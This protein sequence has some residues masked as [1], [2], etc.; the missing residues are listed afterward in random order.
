[1]SQSE[2]VDDKHESPRPLAVARSDDG[3]DTG[4]DPPQGN[5]IVWCGR[6]LGLSASWVMPWASASSGKN[7]CMAFT[8]C[9]LNRSRPISTDDDHVGF[10]GDQIGAMSDRCLFGDGDFR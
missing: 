7:S 9:V 10:L 3:R 6:V 4:V 8:I 2:A 1:M 5:G